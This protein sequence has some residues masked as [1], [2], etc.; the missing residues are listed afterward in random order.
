M[1]VFQDR[2]AK[3][4]QCRA[5][6]KATAKAVGQALYEEVLMRFG[7]P[8]VIIT[9]NGTQYTGKLFRSWLKDMGIQHRLTP[10][11]THIGGPRTTQSVV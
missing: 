5:I 10:P 6:R 8:K 2:F 3:W 11:Y 7:C 4:V 1:V 9:D